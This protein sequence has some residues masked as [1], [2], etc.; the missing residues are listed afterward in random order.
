MVVED[1]AAG[2]E[3]LRGADDVPAIAPALGEI[4]AIDATDIPVCSMQNHNFSPTP[5]SCPCVAAKTKRPSEPRNPIFPKP[6]KAEAKIRR[7]NQPE[8]ESLYRGKPE[9]R[10]NDSVAKQERAKSLSLRRH[11]GEP[12][13]EGHTR[14]EPCA[15]CHRVTRRAYNRKRREAA[16]QLFIREKHDTLGPVEKRPPPQLLVTISYQKATPDLPP[17]TVLPEVSSYDTFHPNGNPCLR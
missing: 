14:C 5:S 12:A 7:K 2:V 1:Y 8:R 3:E 6:R 13:I 4:L 16:W 17:Q 10:G 9:E 15:E 11:C